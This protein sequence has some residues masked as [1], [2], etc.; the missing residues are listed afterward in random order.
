VAASARRLVSI[1]LRLTPKDPLEALREALN[2]I[3][4]TGARVIISHLVYMYTGEMLKQAAGLIQKHRDQGFEVWVDSGMYTA[5]TTGIG[6]PLFE[7]KVFF[8]RGLRLEKL[9]AATGK[10]AGQV[11]DLEKFRE[12][13]R[14][15]P[16]DSIIYEAGSPEDIFTAYALPDVMVST[17]SG[18]APPGQGHPQGAATYPFF[19]RV[20]A[21]ES[22]RLSLLEALRRCTL[23]PAQAL[24]YEGKGRL[25]PGADAD[26][27]VLDWDR[28]RGLPMFL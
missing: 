4:A 19:F 23:L 2:L 10:Y 14:D 5:F 3:S 7:E 1:H 24:G 20:M 12:M 26:L 11:L 21:R 27:A 18:K 6:T 22:R 25:S 9:R 8:E 13:R 28:L 15:F 17:D 16:R